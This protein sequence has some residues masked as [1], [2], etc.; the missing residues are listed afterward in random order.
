[1]YIYFNYCSNIIKQSSAILEADSR[2]QAL[3]E[4]MKNTPTI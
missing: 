4:Q 2:Q 3:I 1:M